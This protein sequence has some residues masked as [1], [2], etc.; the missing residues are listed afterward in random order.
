MERSSKKTVRKAEWVGTEETVKEFK[1]GKANGIDGM[2]A[3][4]MIYR[5]VVVEQMFWVC[6]LAWK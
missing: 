5:D 2:T 3:E 4:M 1:V 6:N